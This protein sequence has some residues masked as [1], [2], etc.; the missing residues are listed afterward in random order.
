MCMYRL[1]VGEGKD[2]DLPECP[3]AKLKKQCIKYL[4]PVRI[5]P[6]WL[7]IFIQIYAIYPSLEAYVKSYM[8][9]WL[10]TR[11]EIILVS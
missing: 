7:S 2:L 11:T 4:G 6:Q 3:R 9:A 5:F 1:D 8:I 10:V